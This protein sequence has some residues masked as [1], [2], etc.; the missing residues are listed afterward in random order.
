M[1][2]KV[3]LP[4]LVLLLAALLPGA[5]GF[6]PSLDSDFT[7]TLPAGRKEC[8]FQPMPFKA[9]LE[10]EYQVKAGDGEPAGTGRRGNRE[11]AGAG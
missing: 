9:S 8:F 7:F 4:C 2:A 5:A 1:G 6:A 11:L 10:I 3:W